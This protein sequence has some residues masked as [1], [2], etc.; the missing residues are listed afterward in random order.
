MPN[1]HETIDSLNDEN[2]SE[3]KETLKKEANTLHDSN[4]QLYARAKKAEGFEKKGDKWVK[5]EKP[6]EPKKPDKPEKPKQSDEP[7]YGKLAFLNSKGI[8]NPDDQKIVTDE[9]TRLKL[10]V[11]DILEMKHIKSKL[12]ESKTQREAEDGMPG[13]SKG[14]SSG[15]KASVDHWVN[16]KDK[17]GNY[18]SPPAELG[19]EFANKV[20][21]ARMKQEKEGGMFSDELHN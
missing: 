6:A 20:I 17:K 2:V 14:K 18:V 1:L 16:K 21:D 19:V 5:K 7:D 15:N 9:A 10:P 8:D 11:T 3:V 4:K 12:K 13:D